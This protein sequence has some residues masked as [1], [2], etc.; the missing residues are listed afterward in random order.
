MYYWRVKDSGL[1]RQ[2]GWV[3]LESVVAQIWIILPAKHVEAGLNRFLALCGSR[4]SELNHIGCLFLV[5]LVGILLALLH[6]AEL[7][8]IHHALLTSDFNKREIWIIEMDVVAP[9]EV[10]LNRDILLGFSSCLVHQVKLKGLSCVGVDSVYLEDLI[11]DFYTEGQCLVTQEVQQ[12]NCGLTIACITKIDFDV[13]LIQFSEG[14]HMNRFMQRRIIVFSDILEQMFHV[15]DVAGTGDLMSE[16]RDGRC[17]PECAIGHVYVDNETPSLH[18]INRR[19]MG[20]N[21]ARIDIYLPEPY[22]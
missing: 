17:A 18:I 6:K 8:G 16:N 10:L 19:L 4:Y 9:F 1:R 11:A 12:I 22:G 13:V 15:F 2:H 7:H 5:E 21:C 14:G 20:L 3:N